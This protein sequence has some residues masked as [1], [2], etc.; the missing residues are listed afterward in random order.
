ML[1]YLRKSEILWDVKERILFFFFFTKDKTTETVAMKNRFRAE[2]KKKKKENSLTSKWS[3]DP[4]P[5][6]EPPSLEYSVSEVPD[7]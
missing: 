2:Q 1:S 6:T 7:M 4:K 5:S 3:E